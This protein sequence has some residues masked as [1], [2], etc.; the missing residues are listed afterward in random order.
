[1]TSYN[2]IM[3]FLLLL[4]HQDLSKFPWILIF[5]M[6]RHSLFALS[7]SNFHSTIY[8]IISTSTQQTDW[9]EFQ[10]ES[11]GLLRNNMTSSLQLYSMIKLTEENLKP[12]VYRRD[13][14]RII[15][16]GIICFVLFCAFFKDTQLF[17][18][19]RKW[20]NLIMSWKMKWKRKI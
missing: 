14:F 12:F 4:S 3:T 17:F 19:Y 6:F 11:R 9:M 13:S 7:L 2:H 10:V 20:K 15:D 5:L 18:H 1:M 16:T 8:P